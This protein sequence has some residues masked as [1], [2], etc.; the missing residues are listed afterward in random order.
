M[1]VQFSG[2]IDGGIPTFYL[3]VFEKLSKNLS[4]ALCN[5]NYGNLDEVNFITVAVE[6]GYE[7]NARRAAKISKFT[8]YAHPFDKR[9]VRAL[10]IALPFSLDKL[11]SS[12]EEAFLN[13]LCDAGIFVLSGMLMKVPKDIDYALLKEHLIETLQTQK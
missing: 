8:S 2:M 1:K 10:F 7:E 9:R 12:N 13:Q 3:S 5:H 6:E 4:D 11:I